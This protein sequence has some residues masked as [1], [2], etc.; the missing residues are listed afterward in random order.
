[1]CER[2][3]TASWSGY[4]HQGQVGLLIA[5]RKIQEVPDELDSHFI[6]FET[7]EDAAIYKL[8][9]GVDKD[10][11]SVH[12]VKAYYSENSDKKYK[13]TK[14][15]NEPFQA[16]GNDYLHTAVEITDWDT[17]TVTN[18]NGVERF[19]YAT[20]IYH[21][22]TNEIGSYIRAELLKMLGDD[23]GRVTSAL[24]HLT[25]ALDCK[26]REEH[27]KADRTLFDISFSLAAIDAVARDIT[28]FHI[29]KIYE[30][31]RDF[32]DLYAERIK[33]ATCDQAHIDNIS[34]TILEPIYQM[35]DVEFMAF[36]QRLNLDVKQEKGESLNHLFNMQ[37]FRSVFFKS[38][39]KVIAV[40]PAIDDN[41]V[42]YQKAGNPE[43][44]VISTITRE[45]E[46]AG[47]VVEHILKNCVSQNIFWDN[48]A[49]VNHAISGSLEELNPS[50]M[51]V[52]NP[53]D[54]QDR[55]MALSST[56]RLITLTDTLTILNDE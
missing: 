30:A 40:I 56:N 34:A 2:N 4:C 19:A 10:Y 38:L 39:M 35:P 15:L 37:G 27:R 50:I 53:P 29:S 12:Q 51:H 16:S 54:Q 44:F 24:H 31:R 52:V 45:A 55:F 11:L 18:T 13:Y 41:V 33:S 32:S 42:K 47:V 17:S 7:R 43:K 8:S 20:G 22:A 25:F 36:L 5:L 23:Q 49:I 14:V 46:E 9:N 26:I 48:H 1:M 3:A 21:C 28:A 6:E